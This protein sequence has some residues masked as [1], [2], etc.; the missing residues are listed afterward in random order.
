MKKIYLIALISLLSVVS[1]QI[2]AQE[3]PPDKRSVW[4]T[5]VQKG[6]LV[7]S[8]DISAIKGQKTLNISISKRIQKMGT[9]YQPDSVFIANRVKEFNDEKPGKGDKWLEEWNKEKNNF[10]TVFI[11]GFNKIT[12]KSGIKV[13]LNDPSVEY[14]CLITTKHL[15]AYFGKIYVILDMDVV[16]TNDPSIIV[17]TVRFPVV[18]GPLKPKSHQEKNESA[19]YTAGLTFGRYYNKQAK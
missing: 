15:M 8:G 3:V 4:F 17:A 16:K 10:N 19:Y 1:I 5:D 14:T 6:F 7:I 13:S 12:A 2:V 9:K 11:E 18:C